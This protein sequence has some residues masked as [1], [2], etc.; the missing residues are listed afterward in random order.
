MSLISKNVENQAESLGIFNSKVKINPRAYRVQNNLSVCLPTDWFFLPCNF[1]CLG[2]CFFVQNEELLRA[3]T[4]RMSV[5]DNI[6]KWPDGAHTEC[7][8]WTSSVGEKKS[9]HIYEKQ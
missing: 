1:P 4:H 7:Y 2:N 5:K 9:Y 8:S 3:A 6:V